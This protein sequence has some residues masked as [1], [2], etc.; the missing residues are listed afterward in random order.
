MFF[1]P[2]RLPN[3]SSNMT[4]MKQTFTHFNVFI[5]PRNNFLFYIQ[6][7]QT[8]NSKKRS[9]MVIGQHE[10]VD[11][12]DRDLDYALHSLDW[13]A[14][15]VAFTLR[16]NHACQFPFAVMTLPYVASSSGS[17]AVLRLLRG[18][19]FMGGIREDS[20]PIKSP[21]C[22]RECMEGLVS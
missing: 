14:S 16:D 22:E 4:R 19:A 13:R 8:K 21:N 18:G 17:S 2:E 3:W 15:T 1:M 11:A 5:N 10:V 12:M 7:E 20:T 9:H 6:K